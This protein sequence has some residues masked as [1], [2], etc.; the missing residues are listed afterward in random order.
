MVSGLVTSPCDQLRIFSGLASMM[1]MASKSV[2]GLVSSNG[3]ERNKVTLLGGPR[4]RLPRLFPGFLKGPSFPGS[5]VCRFQEGPWKTFCVRLR[6][7]YPTLATGTN[8]SRG[9]AP[10][11]IG[12]RCHFR[13]RRLLY[14]VRALDQF[15]VQAKRLQLADEHVERLGHARLN[16]RL[17]LHD[18]FI[19][20][21]PAMN[22]VRFGGEQ[23][24][25]DVSGAV[26]FQRPHLHLAETLPAELRLA[27]QRLLSDKR[28][29]PDGTGVNLVVP[30]VREFEHVDV[31]R[32]DWLLKLFAGHAV[33]QRRLAR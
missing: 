14:Q 26:G 15:H 10:R 24:L 8:T 31:A 9:W 22:V 29:R 21:R 18:C 28:V 27:A 12:D 3:F 2:I 5:G 33:V 11:L 13:C 30:Q 1:R 4:R 23:F 17:A 32:R 25:Q 20:L 19:N 6:L 7:S 16:G